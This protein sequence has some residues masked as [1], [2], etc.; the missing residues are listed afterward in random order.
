MINI[1][2]LW[3]RA[4]NASTWRIIV[5]RRRW[6]PLFVPASS[7]PIGSWQGSKWYLPNPVKSGSTFS[8]DWLGILGCWCPSSWPSFSTQEGDRWETGQDVQSHPWCN[9]LLWLSDKLWWWKDHWICPSLWFHGS[10]QEV[11]AQAP[12]GPGENIFYAK[13]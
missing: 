8:L 10:S 6:R 11:W 13:F 12:F 2:E 9:L 7:W 3:K 5:L 1:N 4:F